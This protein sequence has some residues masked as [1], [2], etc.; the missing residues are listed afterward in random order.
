LSVFWSY[1]IENVLNMLKYSNCSKCAEQTD[2]VVLT[3]FDNSGHNFL[4]P[5]LV[6]VHNELK[7]VW[8]KMNSTN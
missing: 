1:L 3:N 8:L 7:F 4:L 6:N 5:T 2:F